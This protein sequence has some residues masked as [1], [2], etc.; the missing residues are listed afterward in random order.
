MLSKVYIESQWDQNEGNLGTLPIAMQKNIRKYE[1]DGAFD[2]PGYLAIVADLSALFM[3]RTFPVPDCFNESADTFNLRVYNT[4]WGPSEFYMGQDAV[5]VNMDLAPQ[6]R[7]ISVPVL[8]I[9]GAFDTM[10]APNIRC[11]F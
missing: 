10:R 3:A 1:A 6:L 5:I 4:L 2:D 11:W 8:L 7:N 9:H